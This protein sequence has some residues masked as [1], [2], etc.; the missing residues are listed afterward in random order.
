M[1][2]ALAIVRRDGLLL[3]VRPAGPGPWGFPCGPVGLGQP[4]AEAALQALV[5]A[6]DVTAE[7]LAL[8][9]PLDAIERHADGSLRA[10]RVLFPVLCRW[11]AGQ[12]APAHAALEMGWWGLPAVTALLP[13][14][15]ASLATGALAGGPGP[16]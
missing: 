8:L 12:G 7:P 1:A 15:L 3:L 14:E 4:L 9:P 2:Q 5:A 6:C 16:A 10:H 11:R 13:P